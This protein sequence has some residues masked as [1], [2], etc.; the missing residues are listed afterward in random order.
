MIKIYY[1][2]S[3]SKSRNA[4]TTL[5]GRN[6][7]FKLINYLENTPSIAE[8]KEIIVKLQCKPHDLIRTNEAIYQANFKGKEF[9]DEEWLQ[10]MHNYP[11]LIQRP[12]IVNGDYLGIIMA[13]SLDFEI[14]LINKKLQLLLF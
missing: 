13:D 4:L 12:I 3:C 11:I 6:L 1:N 2:N 7:E 9:T 8:L 5:K 14:L 10:V